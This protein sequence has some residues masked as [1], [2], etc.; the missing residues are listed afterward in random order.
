MSKITTSLT[1]F[2]KFIKQLTLLEWLVI[3][4]AL[5]SIVFNV[6]A[7]YWVITFLL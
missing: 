3:V 4:V 7:V 2:K 6:Y 1:Q 5:F